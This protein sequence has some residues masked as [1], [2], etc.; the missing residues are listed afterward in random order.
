MQYQNYGD[1]H[2]IEHG[3]LFIAEDTDFKDEKRFMLVEVNPVDD[4]VDGWLFTS[5]CIDLDDVSKKQFEEAID[6]YDDT[7]I[8]DNMTKV[9]YLI[10]HFGH[11]TFDSGNEKIIYG[12]ENIIQELSEYGIKIDENGKHTDK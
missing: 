10:N 12:K 9:A 5:S 11:F 6:N 4:L 1:V 2:P 8:A 7:I 3:A